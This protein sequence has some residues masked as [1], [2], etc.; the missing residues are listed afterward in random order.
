MRRFRW[1]VGDR[2]IGRDRGVRGETEG[3][4]SVATDVFTNGLGLAVDGGR[5]GRGTEGFVFVTSGGVTNGL[6]VADGGG[7]SGGGGSWWH[8]SNGRRT[9]EAV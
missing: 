1:L 3:F 6:G 8:S 7:G 5:G 4:F 2:G 9:S